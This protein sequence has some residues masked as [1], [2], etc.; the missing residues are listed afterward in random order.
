MQQLVFSTGTLALDKLID[1]VLP[2]DNIVFQVDNLGDFIHYAH[3]FCYDNNENE[4]PLI[5]FRFADHE[6][7]LPENA[8][9]EVFKLHPEEGFEPFIDNIFTTIEKFGYGACYIFD[10][11]SEL[12]VDWYS[13]RMVANFFML[14][15]PYLFDYKTVTFFVLLRDRHSQYTIS[16][17]HETAQVILDVHNKEKKQYIHP[18]KVWKRH[19]PTMYMLHIWSDE[20]FVPI[21]LSAE[22][23]DILTGYEQTWTD[24]STRL[25]NVRSRTFS[26]AYELL[27]DFELG[28]CKS[29]DLEPIKERIIRMII[30]RDQ[31][32]MSMVKKYIRLRDLLDIG[33]RMI[34]SGLIGGKSVGLLLAQAIIKKSNSKW[35]DKLE[36]HDSFFIGSDVFFTYLVL[37]KCWWPRYRIRKCE[38]FDE[39]AAE[40]RDILSNGVFPQDIVDQF[41]NILNYFG[42]SPIIVRSSSLLEDAYG[43]AF[44]GKYESVFL[45]NQGTPDERLEAFINAVRTVYESTLSEDALNYRLRRKLLDQDEQMAILVQRVS[46]SPYG[47]LFFPQLAGVGYSYNPFLWNK[48]IDPR[49]GLIRL[50]FGLGTRAVNRHDDDYTRIVALNLPERRPEANKN[51]RLKYN[52]R[53]V[54]VLNLKNNSF[55]SR[56]FDEL[57]LE[58][59]GLPIEKFSSRDFEA[60][61][62]LI[63]RGRERIIYYLDLD[64]F[65][66]KSPIVEDMKEMLN[67][68]EKAYDYPVDIEFTINYIHENVYRIYILQCRPLQVRSETDEFNEP[69]DIKEENI[70]IKTT[71]PV[72]GNGKATTIDR[73]IYVV[74]EKYGKLSI[75]ERYAVARIIGKI[76]RMHKE[77]GKETV[78]LAGPGRWATS[79]PSLGVPATFHEIN[80]A[81]IICEIAEMHENL[82]PDASLGTHFFNDLVETDMFYMAIN[83]REEGTILKRERFAKMDNQLTQL[84]PDSKKFENLIYVIDDQRM[85]LYADPFKQIALLYILEEED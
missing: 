5:Y 75:Q 15:C 36:R 9:A 10:S 3:N 53:K 47:D 59:D 21:R 62:R 33:R 32:L 54:D 78:F 35:K 11:L 16:K 50:V 81:S 25:H 14:T 13:D 20:K 41:R 60:E 77:S 39:L 18:L 49:A 64:K 26:Q 65:I 67:T 31:N 83:P 61:S 1:G 72:I 51:E 30:T 57:A 68:L 4:R 66:L 52:Q 27:R 69:T 85:K 55:N 56:F 19:S 58:A 76:N 71:G 24:L 17:I 2:G 48:D 44:S 82:N 73:F 46:G 23:S 80:S 37:N 70:L 34:G 7:L 12:A 29:Q 38:D 79:S 74:P 6:S 28:L 84:I 45:A 40:G 8:H 43:N 22:I 42:Q 63:Q